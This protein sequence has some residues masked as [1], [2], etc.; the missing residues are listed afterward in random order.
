MG[1]TRANDWGAGTKVRAWDNTAFGI[2]R[3]KM[4]AAISPDQQPDDLEH[5][6]IVWRDSLPGRLKHRSHDLAFCES[7]LPNWQ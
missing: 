7:Y 4:G 5:R 3:L 2:R 1:L 6:Y